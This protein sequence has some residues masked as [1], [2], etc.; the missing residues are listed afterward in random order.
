MKKAQGDTLKKW[1]HALRFSSRQSKDIQSYWDYF[2][3]QEGMQGECKKHQLTP[4]SPWEDYPK[5]VANHIRKFLSQLKQNYDTGGC[6]FLEDAQNYHANTLP[7]SLL[8]YIYQ[9]FP[10]SIKDLQIN[11]HD[12]QQLGLKG[13]EI[14]ATLRILLEKV[15]EQPQWNQKETLFKLIDSQ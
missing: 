8:I 4:D 15:L 13:K 1:S 7:I 10:L 3:F 14:G 9:N 11:G 12:L 6:T 5:E 2:S